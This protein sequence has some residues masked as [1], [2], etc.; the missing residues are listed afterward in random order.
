MG[1]NKQ[2]DQPN[3]LMLTTIELVKKHGIEKTA[4]DTLIPFGWLRKFSSGNFKNPSVN[5]VVFI[6]EHLTNTKII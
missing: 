1:K 5:R 6:Y 4:F 3:V 2:Y